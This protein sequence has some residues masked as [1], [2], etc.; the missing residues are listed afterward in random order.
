MLL[1]KHW[2]KQMK[3]H[4][5]LQNDEK[6]LNNEKQSIEKK[7]PQ[8]NNEKIITNEN[9]TENLQTTKLQ[10]SKSSEI[11]QPYEIVPDLMDESLEQNI[12][13]SEEDNF[14]F[15]VFGHCD[16]FSHSN[17][18]G[19]KYGKNDIGNGRKILLCA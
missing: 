14:Q 17:A 6:D 12:M 4:Q 16:S 5:Q 10:V 7:L 3:K 19:S 18:T 15:F 2:K 8:T 13:G 9:L 1:M 11:Q